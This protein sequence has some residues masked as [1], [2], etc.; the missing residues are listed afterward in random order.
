MI[1]R[2]KGQVHIIG[3]G[4]LGT[5]IGLALHKLSVDVS[6][7]DSSPAVTALSIDFGAGR[8]LSDTDRDLVSL[9][10]VCVPPDVTASTVIK[11]LDRF[12]NAIVTDV[13]SVKVAILDTVKNS[14]SENSRYVGSHPMAGREKGGALA[15]RA[16]L[17]VGRPWLIAVD[18][19]TR[20]DAVN[21]VEQLV[22]DL[23]ATTVRLSAKEHDHAVALVSHAPQIVSSLLAARLA[24]AEEFDL[25]LAGQGLRDTTRIAASDPKLWLQILSM[26]ANELLPIVKEFQQD[27]ES[28]VGALEDTKAPGSLSKISNLLD[29]GNQGISKLPGKHG[30][31]STL[32]AQVV[33][34]IDDKP[35]ELARL[36]NE[37]GRA[38]VN[39]EDLQLD[40]ATGAQV[41]LVE[42]SVLPAVESDLIETLVTNGWRMAG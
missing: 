9:V 4:L 16:D 15:G 35:G 2:T 6:L 19:D 3:A 14:S 39:I 26:N 8:S 10:V 21:R 27:L 22:L 20:L 33:V 38:G 32:Y 7:E 13:A 5:S 12:P 25:A 17:F 24:K 37:I 42:L 18:E 28:I 1:A 31:R 30:A 41:G 11:A 34:M 23:G 36:L 29:Q 40:H